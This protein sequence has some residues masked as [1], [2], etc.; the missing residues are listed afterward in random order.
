MTEAR[1]K[2]DAIHNA[3][4]VL[5]EA[6]Y[7]VGNLWHINDVQDRYECDDKTAQSILYD[8]LTNEYI[9]ERIFAQIDDFAE[10]EGLTLKNTNK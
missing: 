5:E 1:K 8:G 9:V 6:G 2:I 7:F 3:K 4:D 10:C